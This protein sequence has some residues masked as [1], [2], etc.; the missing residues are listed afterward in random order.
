MPLQ[1]LLTMNIND[2]WSCRRSGLMFILAISLGETYAIAIKSNETAMNRCKPWM[3]QVSGQQQG[4]A[5]L[6]DDC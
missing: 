2:L 1:N 6:I 3:Q 4:Q 5:R